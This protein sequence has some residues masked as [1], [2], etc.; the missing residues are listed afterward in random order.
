M[1]FVIIKRVH[2]SDKSRYITA[3]LFRQME[4]NIP[5]ILF[6]SR[7]SYRLVHV[8]RS[9]IIGSDHQNP[10]FVNTIQV[11]QKTHGSLR[12]SHRITTFVNERIDFQFVH[13]SCPV[14]KLPQSASPRTGKRPRVQSA[15]DHGQKLQ[16][17]R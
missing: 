4:I 2:G 10:I 11:L 3:G 17:L 13:L 12:G 8:T 6:T 7:S 1:L 9:A 14:H 15:L 16:L 5:I